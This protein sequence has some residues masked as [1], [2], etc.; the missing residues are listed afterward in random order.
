MNKRKNFIFPLVIFRVEFRCNDKEITV[1]VNERLSE[2]GKE[3]EK[4]LERHLKSIQV[5]SNTMISNT[6]AI[7][8]EKRE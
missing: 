2:N 4:R 7:V 1:G 6:M 8:S 5:N 3:G